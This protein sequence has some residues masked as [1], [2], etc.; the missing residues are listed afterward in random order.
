MTFV[1]IALAV[2]VISIAL[3]YKEVI[4]KECAFTG[5]IRKKNKENALITILLLLLGIIPGIIYIIW[6]QSNKSFECPSCSSKSVIPT[7]SPLGKQLVQ[8]MKLIPDVVTNPQINTLV[9]EVPVTK[10]TITGDTTLKEFLN[11]KQALYIGILCFA[12][13]LL[14]KSFDRSNDVSSLATTS[15]VERK[16]AETKVPPKAIDT[17]RKSKSKPQKFVWDGK[18]QNINCG[19]AK[20]CAAL[21]GRLDLDGRINE[22]WPY[23]AVACDKGLDGAC[24]WVG[25]HYKGA[26]DL[27]SARKW[28]RKACDID[29]ISAQRFNNCIPIINIDLQNNDIENAK[30]LF[31]SICPVYDMMCLPN[32]VDD[33]KNQK[34]VLNNSTKKMLKLACKEGHSVSCNILVEVGL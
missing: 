34:P 18:Y 6:C 8:K 14:N 22:S 24:Y 5:R 29:S 4:C 21:G 26:N 15:Q 17:K 9:A 3:S 11:S 25:S 19:S 7:D 10:T 20:E 33:Y 16:I 28:Y 27:S 30:N 31:K 1:L 2:W 13:Y 12:V 32:I 23:R